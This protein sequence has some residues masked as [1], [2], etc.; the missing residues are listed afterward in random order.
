MAS[1]KALSPLALSHYRHRGGGEG[2]EGQEEKIFYH[3]FGLKK[4][5]I[6]KNKQTEFKVQEYGD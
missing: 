4:E 3:L 1:K 5:G 2:V 6:N